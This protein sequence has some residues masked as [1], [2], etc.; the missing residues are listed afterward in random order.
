M[1]ESATLSD[2]KNKPELSPN[3]HLGIPSS[4]WKEVANDPISPEIFQNVPN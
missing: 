2:V 3:A 1:T 4:E